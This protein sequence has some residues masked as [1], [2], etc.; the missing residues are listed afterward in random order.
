MCV[1]VRV[2][3]VNSARRLNE[4]RE[5]CNWSKRVSQT[6]VSELSYLRLYDKV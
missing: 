6:A 5:G 1:L 4:H 2:C 3:D